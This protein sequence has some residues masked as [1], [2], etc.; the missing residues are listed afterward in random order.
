MTLC[1]CEIKGGLI[2]LLATDD[3]ERHSDGYMIRTLVVWLAGGDREETS[4]QHSRADRDRAA[5]FYSPTIVPR[6]G[7]SVAGEDQ[8]L[9][10]LI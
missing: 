5:R 1:N 3:E 6:Q 2:D 10:A 9:P 8:F 4:C 7:C